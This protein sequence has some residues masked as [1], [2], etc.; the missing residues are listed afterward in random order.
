MIAARGVAKTYRTPWGKV[1]ALSEVS[2]E[3]P[4]GYCLLVRGPS[5]SGKTTLLNILGCLTLPTRGEVWLDGED[6][7]HLPDHFRSALRRDKIGFVFQQYHLLTGYTAA[8]NV[9]MPLLPA[10]V[11][12]AEREARAHSVLR[13]L[14]LSARTAFDVSRL[15]GGEQQRVAIARALICDPPVV[16]ADEPTANVDEGTAAS[17]LELL[18]SLKARGKTMVIAAHDQM[19]RDSGIV[20]QELS[21]PFGTPGAASFAAGPLEAQR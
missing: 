20:D 16:I 18:A 17:I 19:W 9:T 13:A 4:A 21:L 5:G 11:A 10:G 8:E 3:M 2:I 15:S 7:C 6:V 1:E 12:A 14:G